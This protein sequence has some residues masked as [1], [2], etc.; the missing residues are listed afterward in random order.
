MISP[1]QEKREACRSPPQRAR[2]ARHSLFVFTRNTAACG[3]K[4]MG[5]VAGGVVGGGGGEGRGGGGALLKMH[6]FD[7]V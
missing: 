3:M 2:R 6:V 4:G 7:V 5:G 1:D